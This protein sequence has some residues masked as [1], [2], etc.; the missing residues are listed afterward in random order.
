MRNFAR[1]GGASIGNGS[2][3]GSS[4]RVHQRA[5]LS[6]TI[7]VAGSVSIGARISVVC[8]ASFGPGLTVGGASVR[9]GESALLSVLK[10]VEF[11]SSL[12]TAAFVR[13]GISLSVMGSMATVSPF[14][15]SSLCLFGWMR[16]YNYRRDDRRLVVR[17]KPDGWHV[18]IDTCRRRTLRWS[19][20][21]S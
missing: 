4:L 16:E 2:V 1:V 21:G 13:V 17:A 19:H 5:T 7:F 12:S 6:S 20:L 10:N 14:F 8:S 15:R 3:I 18:P 9:L 11:G